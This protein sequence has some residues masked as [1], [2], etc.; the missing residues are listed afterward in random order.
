MVGQNYRESNVAYFWPKITLAFSAIWKGQKC[1]KATIRGLCCLQILV[2]SNLPDAVQDCGQSEED[3]Y[4][5]W[6]PMGFYRRPVLGPGCARVV[7]LGFRQ[8]RQHN[9]ENPNKNA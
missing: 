3:K 2:V 1:Q 7:E 9:Y 4:K 5:P 8:Q 6:N